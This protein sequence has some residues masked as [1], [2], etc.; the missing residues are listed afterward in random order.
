MRNITENQ[1]E[2]IGKIMPSFKEDVI[3]EFADENEVSPDAPLMKLVAGYSSDIAKIIK[4]KIGE[5]S[6]QLLQQ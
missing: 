4:D 2:N 1:G 5:E 6:R 3:K